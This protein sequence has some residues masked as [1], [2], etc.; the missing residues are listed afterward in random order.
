MSKVIVTIVHGDAYL[1]RWRAHALPTWRRYASRHGY[2][3]IIALSQRL[4]ESPRAAGRSVAWQK[5]LIAGHPDIQ[6]HDVAVW[7][8]ADVVINHNTAPCIVEAQK[9]DKIGL[10]E[11]MQLPD[12]PLFSLMIARNEA[13]LVDGCA[14][15]GIPHPLEPFKRYGLSETPARYF[16]TGVMVFRPRQHRELLEAVYHGYEDRGA[17]CLYEQVPFSYEIA[18][19]GM[20]EILDPKFNVLY[21]KFYIALGC[22]FAKRAVIDGRVAILAAILSNVYF[23]HFASIQYLMPDLALL[24]FAHQPIRLKRQKARAQAMRELERPD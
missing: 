18:R 22:N 11:E 6:K 2:A 15:M 5:L 16:N 3:G 12:H 14:R 9:T 13:N 23:L 4:D 19:R 1:Q 10:C 20:Y 21:G 8:D 7:I 17:G 24:D